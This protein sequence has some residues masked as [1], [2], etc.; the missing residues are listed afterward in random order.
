MGTM[1][2]KK[3]LLRH[4]QAAET[5]GAVS[6]ICTDKTSTLKKKE[7]TVQK[8]WLPGMEVQIGGAGY[9][10][11]GDFST[12]GRTI[13]PQ[14]YP[15]LMALLDAGRKCNNARIEEYDQGWGVI[16]SPTEAALIV[17]A[18]KAGLK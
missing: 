13:E 17:A 2:R 3:A 7:M 15:A 5:L 18:E 1:A 16:G 4:L 10:P 14:L 9:N 12:K 11:H 8:I 6:V